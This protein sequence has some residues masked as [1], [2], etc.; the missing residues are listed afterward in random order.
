MLKKLFWPCLVLLL[1][2][3]FA[4]ALWSGRAA[5]PKYVEMACLFEE[6][7]P[8]CVDSLADWKSGLAFYD[9]SV[10]VSRDPLKSLT[11]LL[12]DYWNIEFAGAG[13]AAVSKDAVLPLQVLKNRKS[14]CMGLAWL[15]MMVAE[16]RNLPLNVILLPGHVFL[17]YGKSSGLEEF[18]FARK[19][20][21]LEPNRRGYSYTD[22]E[23]REK[24]KNGHWTGLEFK[25]LKSR[26]FVGLAAFDLGNLYLEANPRRALAW[27]RMAEEFFPEYPGIS[28]N[29]E[30]AK[31]KVPLDL[32]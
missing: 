6:R 32:P 3:A 8:G 19:T 5:E 30:I 14:G 29:Q 25:P 31:K 20:V 22:E 18:G 12:W 28:V 27:Y 1:T 15:A 23:Y 9:S 4:V 13:E 11:A 21:N 17:R 2:V 7:A 26:E 16:A 10:A 24:Y